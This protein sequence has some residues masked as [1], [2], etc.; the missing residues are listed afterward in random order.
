ME[1][2]CQNCRALLRVPEAAAGRQARCPACSQPFVIPPQEELLEELIS[3]WI[4]QDVDE[5]LS[6]RDQEIQ[7]RL[8]MPAEPQPQRSAEPEPPR[9]E[10]AAPPPSPPEPEPAEQEEARQPPP[11]S[12]PQRE[13]DST[14]S[15]ADSPPQRH[16][17]YWPKA[18]F[19]TPPRPPG[20][21]EISPP[22]QQ[23][24]HI[25]LRMDPA[26]A[27]PLTAP[28][29]PRSV[30]TASPSP[31]HDY[32]QDLH[33]TGPRP[34]LVVQHCDHLGV[35]FAFDAAWLSHP[36]FQ[37]S[38]PVRCA[39]SGNTNRVQL[40]ARPILFLDRSLASKPAAEQ[41]ATQHEFRELGDRSPR[42]LVQM[43]GRIESM[44]HPFYCPLPYYVS[45]KHAKAYLH[46]QTHDRTDGGVTCEVVIPDIACALEWLGRVNGVCGKE[47]ELL[48]QEVSL[49]HGEAWKALSEPCRQRIAT[50]CRLEPRELLLLYLND[51]DFGRR[52]EGLAGLILT[53]QRLAFCK[54]HHRGQ[55]P[56]NARNAVILARPEG[57]FVNLTLI[58]GAERS[59]MIKLHLEDLEPL[60]QALEKSPGLKLR[61]LNEG[62]AKP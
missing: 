38:F 60:R 31:S 17:I 15:E 14:A 56:L 30:P 46:A 28:K 49:L 41:I 44:P 51:A 53:N 22:A 13:A 25:P 45:T 61:I 54:Y 10:S 7:Q 36:G 4:E 42:E 18:G 35:R 19:Q 21:E 34:H 24:L 57:K 40:I 26:L 55:V 3:S 9:E 32:P 6:A 43:M 58:V 52:D 48:E 16:R 11:A 23:P 8:F 33:P 47:Y 37:A 59:R 1:V 50:W 62:A 27:D 12:Q 29:L 39:F 5:I 20:V 2:R